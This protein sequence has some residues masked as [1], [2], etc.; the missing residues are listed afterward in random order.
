MLLVLFSS[1]N[2]L[3]SI[4]ILICIKLSPGGPLKL[5]ILSSV[6]KTKWEKVLFYALSRTAFRIS[7][8]WNFGKKGIL[9]SSLISSF[10]V[11]ISKAWNSTVV[12]YFPLFCRLLW[13]FCPTSQLKKWTFSGNYEGYCSRAVNEYLWYGV[14][15]SYSRCL[16]LGVDL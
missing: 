5:I 12:L 16:C 8:S 14:I 15:I 1:K 6:S 7:I 3:L 13:H 9:F 11:W 4:K 10:N 2:R